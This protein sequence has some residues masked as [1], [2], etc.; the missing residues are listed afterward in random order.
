MLIIASLLT[1]HC[2]TNQEPILSQISH[3]FKP[4]VKSD[5]NFLFIF[6]GLE[7]ENN[8]LLSFREVLIGKDKFLTV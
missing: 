1:L 4:F 3:M 8:L 6:I 7:L 2:S 5:I